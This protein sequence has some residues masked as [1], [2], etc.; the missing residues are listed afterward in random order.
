MTS[1]ERFDA[2][3][4]DDLDAISSLWGGFEAEGFATAFQ[5]RSWIEAVKATLGTKRG[6]RFFVVELRERSS[7]K[8]LMLLPFCLWSQHGFATIE[9]VSLG[10][11]DLAMP[12]MASDDAVADAA[13]ARALWQAVLD[14]LPRADLVNI[15]QIPPHYRGR[16]NPLALL[17]GI[18][19]G[20]QLRY[21]APLV[22]DA[23]QVIDAMASTKMRQNLKR[24]ERR[25]AEQG[26]IQFMAAETEQDLEMLLAAMFR[27]R[28]ERF[29][30]LG[31]FDFLAQTEV[32]DFYRLVARQYLDGTG[33]ARLWALLVDGEPVA[34][35][36][37]LVHAKTLHCLVLTMQGGPWEKCSPALVLVSS[38]LV[39]CR[40]NGISLIDY[41]VGEGYHKTGFGGK[42]QMMFDFQ[43]AL[44]LKGRVVLAGLSLLGRS[45]AWIKTHPHLF[46]ATRRAVQQFRRLTGR[47]R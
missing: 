24:S 39:W 16:R 5:M 43:S 35:C 1:N 17:P 10:V 28:Q 34:T 38:L 19:T 30:E 14:V 11:C 46:D 6:A 36:L 15:P 25:L 40:E 2:T 18:V 7:R 23:A 4:H 8:T 33:T 37:G 22:A 21:E 13:D 32:R 20:A 47:R 41:S 44:T 31:R 42:P 29:Q 9:F 12:V 3:R 26:D 45:K 27:Q